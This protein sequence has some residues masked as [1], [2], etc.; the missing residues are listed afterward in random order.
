MASD[1]SYWTALSESYSPM[2]RLFTDPPNE[3]NEADGA[4]EC[5][6]CLKI[7]PARMFIPNPQYRPICL[8]CVVRYAYLAPVGEEEDVPLR[9]AYAQQLLDESDFGRRRVVAMEDVE[10]IDLED[11]ETGRIFGSVELHRPT[12]R[13]IVWDVD[14]NPRLCTTCPTGGLCWLCRR[15]GIASSEPTFSA[16]DLQ[17]LEQYM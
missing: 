1:K 16:A 11:P 17:L 14:G 10:E 12:G 9:P 15:D 13:E 4:T 7:A 8:C 2:R 6:Y 5:D 3:E